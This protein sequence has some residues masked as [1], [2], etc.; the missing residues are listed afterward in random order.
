M[1]T[2]GATIDAGARRCIAWA[3]DGMIFA[4]GLDM[5]VRITEES[6]KRFSTQVYAAESVGSVRL[7]DV[8]VVE[9]LCKE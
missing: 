7:E 2:G 4:T 3:E 9:V 6:T 8:K 1:T 5:T